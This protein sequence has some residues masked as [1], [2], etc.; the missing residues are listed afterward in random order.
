VKD[1]DEIIPEDDRKKMD[2]EE[3]QRQLQ[4][5]NLPPRSRRQVQEVS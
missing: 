1:W 4:E 2:E 5:L 3:V